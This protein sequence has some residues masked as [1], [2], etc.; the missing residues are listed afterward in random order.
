MG[1]RRSRVAG[2]I[3]LVEYYG[4][5][6]VSMVDLDDGTSVPGPNG[7]AAAVRTWSACGV[8][9]AVPMPSFADG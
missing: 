7:G 4:H 9:A 5:D 8:R 1:R 6:H 3:D 2:T